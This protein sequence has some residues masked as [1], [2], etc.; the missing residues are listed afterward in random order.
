MWVGIIVESLFFVISCLNGWIFCLKIIVFGWL[1]KGVF[2]WEL[3]KICLCFGKCLFVVV[4]LMVFILLIK[5]LVSGSNLWRCCE[6]VWLLIV[7]FWCFKFNI[8]VKFKLIFKVNI[9]FVII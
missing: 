2:I 8:G 9:L 4:I 1:L 7:W 3:V 5:Y 6:K